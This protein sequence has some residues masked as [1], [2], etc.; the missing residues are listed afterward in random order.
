MAAS[1]G[2]LPGGGFQPRHGRHAL[3]G[4]LHLLAEAVAIVGGQLPRRLQQAPLLGQ[5]GGMGAL[6]GQ[7]P[8]PVDDLHPPPRLGQAGALLLGRRIAGKQRLVPRLHQLPVHRLAGLVGNAGEGRPRLLPA[9]E[10]V[11]LANQRLQVLR[12]VAEVAAAI[13]QVHRR[14]HCRANSSRSILA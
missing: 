10:L 5:H 9:D 6:L 12:R 14:V 2:R 13:E 3:G 8:Q 11:G 7:V 1:R 4:P